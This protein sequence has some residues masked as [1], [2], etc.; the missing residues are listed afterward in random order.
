[1]LSNELIDSKSLHAN[2]LPVSWTLPFANRVPAVEPLKIDAPVLVRPIDAVLAAALLLFTAPLL[3]SL[4]LMVWMQDGKRPFFAQWRIGRNG[5]LFRC[6]KLRTMVRDAD[7]R[8]RH[9]LESDMEARAEWERDHKL[10][11]DPRVTALGRFLR[12]S[13][14]DE[15]PQLY[16]VLRGDMSIVGPRPIVSSEAAR[17]GRWLGHYTAVRPGITG[18]WQVNGRNSTTYRRRVALDVT[19]VR[20]QSLALYFAILLGTLPAVLFQRGAH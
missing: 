19:F 5:K 6:Y 7:V 10:R 18:L 3:L 9:L 11:R 2:T 16:N 15:L 12:K 17:Y 8:L 14:L 4:A 13:S 20:R 1:M